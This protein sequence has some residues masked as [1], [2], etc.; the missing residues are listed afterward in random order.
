MYTTHGPPSFAG[1]LRG[2]GIDAWH[3]AEHPNDAGT[4]EETGAPED[5]AGT[6]CADDPAPEDARGQYRLL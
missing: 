3:V 6:P 5:V 4:D 1:Y 2:I